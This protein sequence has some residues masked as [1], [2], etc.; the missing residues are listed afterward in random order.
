MAQRAA[1]PCSSWTSGPSCREDDTQFAY[2]V[3]RGQAVLRP[4]DV[5]HGDETH[6]QVVRGVREG[7]R[8]I[9]DPSKDWP[10]EVDFKE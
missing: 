10:K 3:E 8:L 4:V 9:L 5:T 6:F 1:P 2:V 7:D